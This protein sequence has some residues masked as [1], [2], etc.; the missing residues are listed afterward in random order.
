M[1]AYEVLAGAYDALTYDVPYEGILAYWQGILQGRGKSPVSVLDLAC[2]TGTF[3]L[4]LAA[5]G[6]RTLGADCSEEMLVEAV[7]KTAELEDPPYFIRQSMEKLRLP[8]PVDWIVSCLDGF[9]YLT[10]PAELRRAFDA[11]FAALK[12]GGVLSFDVSSPAKLRAMDGQTWL[13]ENDDT[14][15][16]WRTEFE[17]PICWF[18]VDLFERQG[19]LWRRSFEEHRQY[20]WEP[21]T[22]SEQMAAAGFVNVTVHGDLTTDPPGPD[23]Q[24]LFLCGEKP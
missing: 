13:D 23:T 5:R 8:E 20:A 9:N 11:C 3:T 6:Y 7:Q 21:E 16:V 24:R 14:Y 2:G 4:L 15:C 19:S 12:P 22:L 10:D 17:P 18:G 1:S